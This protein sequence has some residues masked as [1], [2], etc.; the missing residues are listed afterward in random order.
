[1]RSA[2]QGEGP[3]G[4]FGRYTIYQHVRLRSDN[5]GIDKPQEK[6]STNQ[7][8]NR[9]I[10]SFRVFPL[11]ISSLHC[12]LRRG[13]TLV[14]D[15]ICLQ[16][17]RIPYGTVSMPSIMVAKKVFAISINIVN[18]GTMIACTSA[19]AA[20][21]SGGTPRGKEGGRAPVSSSI[22]WIICS[23]TYHQHPLHLSFARERLTFRGLI[24]RFR[25]LCSIK[26]LMRSAST[27][28]RYD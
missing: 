28:L 25:S 11:F 26:L 14:N 13:L 27:V 12:P 1:M 15:L 8:T 10:G 22:C 2:Y 19:L 16:I 24:S 5:S 21:T 3:S 9:S 6:E 4:M 18:R 20:A 7:R 17:H 23:Y